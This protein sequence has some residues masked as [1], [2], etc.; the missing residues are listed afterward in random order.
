MIGG[1][2]TYDASL[3]ELQINRL[4]HTRDRRDRRRAW[5]E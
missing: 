5:R 2:V 3:T 4:G 1:L